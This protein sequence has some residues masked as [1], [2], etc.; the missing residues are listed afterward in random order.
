MN[1]FKTITSTT[2][3]LT[4]E[5]YENA[6]N[7]KAPY[8]QTDKNGIKKHYAICPVCNNPVLIVN[9]YK[10]DYI[11]TTQRSVSLHARHCKK[12]IKGIASYNNVNYYNCP[13]HNETS[14]GRNILRNN[15][16]YNQYLNN[17]IQNNRETIKKH[18]RNI[19]GINFSNNYLDKIINNYIENRNYQYEHT[20]EFNLPYSIIYTSEAFSIFGRYTQKDNRGIEIANAINTKSTYFRVENNKIVKIDNSIYSEIDIQLCH[21]RRYNNKWY[22]NLKVTETVDNNTNILFDKEFEVEN[23]IL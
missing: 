10:T 19:L 5:N 12:S 1:V 13:L 9:L 3:D 6:T 15:N 8:Y 11:D 21:H 14:F 16:N 18:I 22:L 20:T 7:K 17:I 23:I 4:V 2:L